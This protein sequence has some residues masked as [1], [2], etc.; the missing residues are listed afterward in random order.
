MVIRIVR[1]PVGSVDGISL[2]AYQVGR[3]YTVHETIADYLVT[4]GFARVEM[5]S[6]GLTES[7]PQIDRRQSSPHGSPLGSESRPMPIDQDNEDERAARVKALVERV[8]RAQEQAQ[9][10]GIDTSSEAPVQAV[11]RAKTG[12][13][14]RRSKKRRL[15]T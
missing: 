9:R 3:K 1:Q 12:R 4:G 10:N 11:A 5:R 8:Q 15:P 7:A 2:E 14:V 13:P 6:E